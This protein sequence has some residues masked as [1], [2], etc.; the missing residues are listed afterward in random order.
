MFRYTVCR[1]LLPKQS[2]AFI[3]L[4]AVSIYMNVQHADADFCY[5]IVVQ[6]SLV[7]LMFPDQILVRVPILVK[8]KD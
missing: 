7:R 1:F 3:T 2:K 4:V 6:D 8:F 5:V